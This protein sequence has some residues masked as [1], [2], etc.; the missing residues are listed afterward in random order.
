MRRLAAAVLLIAALGAVLTSDLATLL[1]LVAAGLLLHFA[2]A[3]GLGS[4]LRRLAPVF[5]F[6]GLLAGL[7]WL[8]GAA[9]PRLALKTIAVFVLAVPAA[10]VVRWEELLARSQPGSLVFSAALFLLLVRHFVLV[11]GGE[12]RRLLTAQSLAAPRRWRH[13]WWSS[14][15]W[16]L[17]ALFRRAL[18]RAER[19]YAAQLVRGLGS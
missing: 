9:E 10:R 2:M 16:A 5:I 4:G 12:A 11:F 13:G 19:F 18:V 8:G 1:A 3:P 14:L 7:Q 15:V 17:A 6:A